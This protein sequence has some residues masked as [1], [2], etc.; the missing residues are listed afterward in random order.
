ME[1]RTQQ[2]KRCQWRLLLACQNCPVGAARLELH[3]SLG[4][5]RRRLAS[6]VTFDFGSCCTSPNAEP[7]MV[8]EMEICRGFFEGMAVLL[9]FDCDTSR[10]QWLV[11]ARQVLHRAPDAHGVEVRDREFPC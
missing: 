8:E 4:F 1:S 6:F 11:S 5:D 10:A 3:P 7:D 9:G 2:Q